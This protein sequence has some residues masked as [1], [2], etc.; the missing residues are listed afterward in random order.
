MVL[1]GKQT[2][3]LFVILIDV[4]RVNN[5]A[6]AMITVLSSESLEHEMQLSL[7]NQQVES[8]EELVDHLD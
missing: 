4:V 3:L 8:S 2:A 7:L 6:D 1:L 5:A